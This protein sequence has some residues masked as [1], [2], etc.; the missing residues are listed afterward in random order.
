VPSSFFSPFLSQRC[1]RLTSSSSPK[2][3]P[4]IQLNNLSSLH[5]TF[6]VHYLYV[7][8]QHQQTKRASFQ[9]QAHLSSTSRLSAVHAHFDTLTWDETPLDLPAS[10]DN[11]KKTGDVEQDEVPHLSVVRSERVVR[12]SFS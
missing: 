9:Q 10:F 11:A 6:N 12:H 2:R 4:T 8:Q 1:A 3:S 7:P 5:K